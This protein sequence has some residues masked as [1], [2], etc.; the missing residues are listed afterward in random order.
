[1]F[2]KSFGALL[3]DQVIEPIVSCCQKGL[4][5]HHKSLFDQ[6]MHYSNMV[7][8][9]VKRTSKLS[10]HWIHLKA[11]CRISSLDSFFV[12]FFSFSDIVK[13]VMSIIR[14]I[15]LTLWRTFYSTS[16]TRRCL[17][18]V[19]RRLL[20]PLIFRT[21]IPIAEPTCGTAW[22]LLNS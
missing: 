22:P 2:L 8:S 1:M 9:N 20:S 10:F 5:S 15:S 6:E 13:M 12:F 14:D 21:L 4:I 17:S 11:I 19:Y 16:V 3:Y 7:E 18:V